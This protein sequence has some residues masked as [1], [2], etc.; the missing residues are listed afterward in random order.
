[1]DYQ[2]IDYYNNLLAKLST[3]WKGLPDKSDESPEGTLRAL[4]LLASGIPKSF[5]HALFTGLPLLSEIPNN[6]L[7]AL[8]EN[9]L[10]GMPLAHITKRQCFMGLEML[11]GPEALIA[12]KE[13]EIV[14]QAALGV[15]EGLV[16]ERG[17][18]NVIDLC[19]GSGNIA[20]AIAC[21]QPVCQVYGADISQEAVMLAKRNAKHLDLAERVEFY[22]G[23]LFT[24]FDNGGF[25]GN[26]DLVVCNPPYIATANI[27]KMPSEISSFEPHLAFDG[28]PFGVAILM[29][30]IRE[31]PRYLK[32]NS[33]LCF[34]VGLGQGDALV[35]RLERSEKYQE[36]R[37]FH[38]EAGN[39]RALIACT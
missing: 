24:P 4:W 13:T 21:H 16:A 18:V 37:T 26:I 20:L 33:W 27:E 14:T 7:E 31:T 35:V 8:I 22:T 36:V 17:Q 19:T 11:A 34:E 29:R 3:S 12:R 15:L 23:D 30:L 25:W 5:E 10:T 6:R 2:N 28:G 32:P 1:M 38:D 39:V 9:R